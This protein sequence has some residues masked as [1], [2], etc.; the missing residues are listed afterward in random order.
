MKLEPYDRNSYRFV[1]HHELTE[2]K[3]SKLW[4]YCSIKDEITGEYVQGV[5]PVFFDRLTKAGYAL[6]LTTEPI[7]GRWHKST[8]LNHKQGKHLRSTL[9]SCYLLK[10]IS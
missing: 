9:F 8:A 7:F 6:V 3:G 2:L 5:Y 4:L 1:R 10:K